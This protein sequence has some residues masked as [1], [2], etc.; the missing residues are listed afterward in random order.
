VRR[1]LRLA[2]LAT[3]AFALLFLTGC[4]GKKHNTARQIP[5]PPPTIRADSSRSTTTYPERKTS[6]HPNEKILYTETGLASW[7]GP[8]YHNRKAANGEIYDQDAMTAAHRTLPFGSRVRVTNEKT[9]ESAVVIINDRGPFVGER[10]I[11]LSRAAAK[12]AGVWR[13]G[14]A[15]VRIDVL[16]APSDIRTGGRWCVQIGAFKDVDEASDLKQ[17][18]IHRYSTAKVIQFSGPTGEWVRVRVPQDDKRQAQQVA[19][20]THTSAQ[21]WLVR[22]D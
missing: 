8:P 10:I 11:D 15:R 7:Y 12:A 3:L 13:A 18:L 6:P 14:I 16:D 22:M 4:G 21:V 1:T 20:N 2:A 9:G 19:D 5:A 17:Q